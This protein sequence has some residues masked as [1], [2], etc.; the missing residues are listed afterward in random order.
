MLEAG[1]QREGAGHRANPNPNLNPDPDPDPDP[2]PDPNPNPNPSPSPNPNPNPKPNPN[3]NQAPGTELP[4]GVKEKPLQF[5][6][7]EGGD[8]SGCIALQGNF[9]PADPDKPTNEWCI[10]TCGKKDREEGDCDVSRCFCADET[11][12]LTFDGNAGAGGGA[13]TIIDGDGPLLGASGSAA[14]MVARQS[15]GEGAGAAAGAAAGEGEG[16]G[17]GEGAAAQA[18]AL[19]PV[20]TAN[21]LALPLPSYPTPPLT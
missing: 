16:E 8:P 1:H 17:E 18:S 4:K 7:P 5:A 3:P 19:T 9:D 20:H 6:L 10:K 12:I 2:N 21:Q 14:A 15:A 11:A 13:A